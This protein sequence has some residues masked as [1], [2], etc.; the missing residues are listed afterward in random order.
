MCDDL[1]LRRTS[2]SCLLPRPDVIIHSDTGSEL[3]ITE[4]IALK[5]KKFCEEELKI[6]FVIVRSHRGSLHDDYMRLGN[7]PMIGARSCT[8]NFK[9]LPQRRYIRSIVGRGGPRGAM[10]AECWLG[11]TTDE[12]N[13]RVDGEDGE[14]GSDV[15]WCGIRYPLLDDHPMS[16]AECISL[17]EQWG[18]EIP[19]SGCWLCPYQGA[20]QWRELRDQHPD[21][22]AIAVK[23]EEIKFSQPRD[24][25][26]IAEGKNVI[27][28]F[29]HKKLAD[30]DEWDLKMARCD[31]PAG[32]FI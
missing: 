12:E 31:S 1:H 7:I 28:L 17:N 13:R 25:E 23:M 32:C 14:S 2:S 4:E 10:L 27:G 19:K 3:P 9:I 18:W 30:I 16:R 15:K 22:F 24:A 6:P 21:L 8:Q 11:I 5:M 29:Q 20:T 26:R